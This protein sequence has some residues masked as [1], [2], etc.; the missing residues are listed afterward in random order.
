M[1]RKGK[2]NTESAS[3][4][5]AAIDAYNNFEASYVI[6]CG[7]A[8]RDDS[9]LTLADAMKAYA[10]KSQKISPDTI[11][12]ET[13]SRDTVG[14]AI[15]SKRNI[16]SNRGWRKL[17]VITSDYHIPRTHEIFTYVYGM[18]YTVNVIGVPTD[19]NEK[20]SEK[21]ITSLYTFHKTFFGINAGDDISMHN[22]LCEKHPYY[23]GLIHP[24]ILDIQP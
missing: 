11:I 5:D 22:R 12:T 14:D 7:W 16:L 15:F 6:T 1:S 13:K 21:E 17:M 19:K 4:M 18:Q 23:N 9:P 3:R 20:Q 2:L 8:Y 10:I 24:K